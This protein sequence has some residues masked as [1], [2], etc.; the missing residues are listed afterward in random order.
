MSG[1]D[2][3]RVKEA[4]D[5]KEVIINETGYQMRGPHLEACPFC[6]HSGCFSIH[7]QGYKCFSCDETGDVF[8]FLEKYRNIDKAAALRAAAA[9]AGIQI[10]EPKPRRERAESLQEKAYR[11][12][13][14]HYH[15]A[16]A[17]EDSPAVQW[18]CGKRGH[19]RQ[20]L[21]KLRMGWATDALLPFLKGHGF[22]DADVI[23]CG[24]AKDKDTKN[25]PITPKDYF[26]HGLSLFPV[27]DQAG[28]VIT[29]TCKDPGKK[30][31]GLMIKGTTKA[32]FINYKALGSEELFCVEGENDVASLFDIGV[33]NTAGTAG[34]PGD[35]QARLL[36]NF[37]SG[38]TLYLWFD[39]DKQKKPFDAG[40]PEGEAGQHH[41]RFIYKRLADSNIT[42]KII[43][44]PGEAK[45]PD[46]YIQGLLKG[47]FTP[48][49][50]KKKIR[51]LATDAVDPLAWELEQL[52]TIPE[53]K[54]R[55]EAFKARKLAQAISGLKVTADQDVYISLAA[56]SIGI[57][58]K[59]VEELV[60]NAVDL[61]SH[62]QT[63]YTHGLKKADAHD[64]A[65]YIYKWF[66]NSAG[67][68]FFKTSDQRVWLFYNRKIFEIGNNLD[69][70]TLMFRLTRLAAIEKPGTTVWYFL[71]TMCNASGE[72]VDV[73]SWLHTDREKDLIFLNLNSAH[74]KIIR[75][76]PSEEPTTI[77]NGTNESSVLLSSSSQIRPFEYMKA[78][79]D[80]EGV[81]ALK[82][83]IMDAT[84]CEG[85]QRYFLLCWAISI[86]MLNYQGDRGLMQVIGS[87]GTGKSKV[88]ERVSYLIYGESYVGKG[89][90]AAETRVATS[91]PVVFLDNLENR[92]LTQPTVDFLLFIANSAHRPKAKS[93]SDTDVIYQRLQSFGMVTSI[94]AFPGRY[95]ELINRTFPLVLEKG[96]RQHGYMHDEVIREIHKKRN[97][98]L[99]A[100]FRLLA[101][102]VLPRLAERQDWSKYIQTKHP[103]HNKERNNE[104]I[105]TMLLILEG[106]LK[107][108]PLRNDSREPKAQG[109]DIL[110]KWIETWEEEAKQTAISSNTLLTFM[111]GLAK[112]VIVK[113]RGKGQRDERHEYGME[114]QSHPE[115]SDETAVYVYEDPEYLETFFLTETDADGDE[116]GNTVEVQYFEFILSAKDLW[117]LF[118]RY[119]ANQHIRNP[120]ENPTSLGARIS[121]DQGVMESAGWKYINNGNRK[122]YKK[123]GGDWYWRFQ[124]KV[125]KVL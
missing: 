68:R 28:R 71:Q 98:M 93:G 53:T 36:K 2:F 108:I 117:G 21:E 22:T 125:R 114:L 12:A 91:N 19:T 62:L 60:N 124:K 13:A 75:I 95:P 4:L 17:M 80:T 24:L 66:S 122:Q 20:T 85:P 31:P 64:L 25:Q 67:A 14:E 50:A 89:T 52:R 26:W 18:F 96:Y 61:Y 112:E 92:N 116:Y 72:P 100:I 41:V 35:E 48:A 94:E 9:I 54:M 70:N 65:N 5:L 1:S 77:D 44:H 105:C 97:L 69:F 82:D 46:E 57:S 23:G 74:N 73:M 40:K 106:L 43:N 120:F 86:F 99:S 121:N 90:G 29:F 102:D 101:Q 103:G 32:F 27:I 118:N 55:L 38:K 83:L 123:I 30:Y 59:G 113:M 15:A 11:L 3:E 58:V 37:C 84:P 45:D 115:F 10:A 33:E 42:V 119:C 110:G 63:I 81:Q 34:A 79:D 87:S 56:K 49:Q 104:H 111:D 78:S 47:G 88:A 8:T 107:Y 39:Q 109:A 76:G 6:S 51:D 7:G 16:A